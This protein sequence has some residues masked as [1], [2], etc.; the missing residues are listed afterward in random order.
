MSF[1]GGGVD[2]KQEPAG[3][4]RLWEEAQRE[5]DPKKLDAIIKRMNVLL[6]EHEQQAAASETGGH[7]RDPRPA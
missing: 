3:W 7:S 1:T 4:R 6:T 2:P 5:R